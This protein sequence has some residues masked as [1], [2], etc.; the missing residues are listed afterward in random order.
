MQGDVAEFR[1]APDDDVLGEPGQVDGDHREDERGLGG[2]VPGG[3]RVDRVVGGARETQIHGDRLG[4]QAQRRAGQCPRAVR[5]HRG[6]VIEVDNPVH[7]TQQRMSVREQVVCQQDGLR[8][9]QMG[10]ARHNGRRVGAG[11]GG[12]RAD[13][14]EHTGGDPSYRVTQPHP[15]QRGHLVVARAS[16]PQPAT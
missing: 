12:E 6:P 10:L 4:I 3:G 13:D 9:L 8:G 15:E 2:K 5:G 7:I 16:G 14:V 11:L 1:G